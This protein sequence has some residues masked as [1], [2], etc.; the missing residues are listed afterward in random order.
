[1]ASL[2]LQQQTRDGTTARGD[3][4]AIMG[5]GDRMPGRNES[6]VY[7]RIAASG[8]PDGIIRPGGLA[9]TERGLALCGFA[10]GS[11]L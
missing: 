4:C 11:R 9:L 8:P 6:M 10:P 2:R 7:E 1:M 3:R 5:S